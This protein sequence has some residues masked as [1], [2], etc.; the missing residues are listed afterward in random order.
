MQLSASGKRRHADQRAWRAVQPVTRLSGGSLMA[1]RSLGVFVLSVLALAGWPAA[2]AAQSGPSPDAPP[3]PPQVFDLD[4]QFVPAEPDFALATLPTTLRMPTGKFSFRL[5]HRFTRPIADGSAGEFFS[6]FFGLDSSAQ[7][8]FELRYGVRPGVQATIY[9]TSD[10]TIQL[11]GQYELAEQTLGHRYATHVFVTIEGRNNLG[12]SDEIAIAD[13]DVFSGAIGGV[14][15]H[16]FGGQ[17]T[18]YAQPIVVLNANV[19]PAMSTESQH[20]LMV[21]LGGRYQIGSSGA[22]V[23]AEA[24]PRLAGFD[25]GVSH[26]SLGLEKVHGA[27][28]FQFNVSNSLGSTLAQVAR[29]GT[30]NDR[31]YIGFNLT[32]KFY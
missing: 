23:L 3:P 13:G 32:R 15:S 30:T 10:R 9:R 2:A 8:G 4:L 16:R 14:I 24:V 1:V 31:W 20:T 26:I 27:H 25:A 28:V 6:D 19:D 21:G 11:L 22:Y 7:V 18:V 17:G 29:G 12:L 5:T